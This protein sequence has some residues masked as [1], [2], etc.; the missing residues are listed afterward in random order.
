MG[1]AT[2]LVNERLSWPLKRLGREGG[3]SRGSRVTPHSW[4]EAAAS[5]ALGLLLKPHIEQIQLELEELAWVLPW[6]AARAFTLQSRGCGWVL[7]GLSGV[8]VAARL[9]DELLLFAAA[10]EDSMRAGASVSVILGLLLR[11]PA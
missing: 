7:L 6:S 1:D 10:L 4:Q 3:S 11:K 5:P 8:A 9:I 2:V